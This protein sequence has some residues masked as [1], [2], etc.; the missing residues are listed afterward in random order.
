MTIQEV[1]DGVIKKTGV[2][3]IPEDQ[4]C[5][6]FMIGNRESQVNKIGTTFMATVDVIKKAKERGIN[7]IIT[8]EPTW[9]TGADDT[10]WL[11]D[12]PVY[13]EKEKL[14]LESNISI[15]RFHDHM[16][17][18][19]EDGIYRGFDQ[20]FGWGQYRMAKIES[21][22]FIDQVGA[23]YEIPEITLRDLC[24][25][26]KRKSDMQVIQIVGNPDMPVRRV[27]V[28]VGGG[29]LGLGVESMPMRLMEKRNIDLAICGDITEWTLPAYIR[30]AAQ[31]GMNKGMLVLGH[32]RSEE[33]GMKHMAEWM[34]TVTGDID[35]EFLDAGE[36]FSYL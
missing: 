26:F 18:A 5:D 4:T 12:D 16:H 21:D 31:M 3:P 28:L 24:G 35:V 1:I 22:D 17:M 32:E 33:P 9:F 6:K 2:D 13:R 27:A 30:D 29:S 25:F 19:S 14:I 11:K 23:C 20:E 10:S 36:P 15:W 8:H 34:K 7:F